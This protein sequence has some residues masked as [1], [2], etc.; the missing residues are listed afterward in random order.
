M[1]F[2]ETSFPRGGAVKPVKKESEDGEV[3]AK[4]VSETYVDADWSV[5]CIHDTLFIS[6]FYFYFEKF[7][8][9]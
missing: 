6:P 9:N 8:K 2:V 7:I 5:L 1:V 3:A 4:I